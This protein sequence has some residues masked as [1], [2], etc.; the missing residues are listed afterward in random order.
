MGEVP[1]RVGVKT[2]LAGSRSKRIRDKRRSH[3]S[4]EQQPHGPLAAQ[5]SMPA[6]GLQLEKQLR[7][8]RSAE[9]QRRQIANKLEVQRN[10]SGATRR[11]VRGAALRAMPLH[12]LPVGDSWFDYPLDD[13][14]NPA[15]NQA[16]IGNGILGH[17]QLQSMGNP[18]P[19]I[20]SL[21]YHGLSATAMLTYE[22]QHEILDALKDPSQWNNGVTADGILVSAG[23]DDVVGDSFAIYLGYKR[24]GLDAIRFQ[25]ILD[26]VQASYLDLFALRDI[27][28]AEVNIDPKQMPIFGHCYD[29]AIPNGEPAGYGLWQ[30]GPW[31][32]PSLNFAGYDYNEGLNIVQTTIDTFKQKLLELAN[33]KIVPPGKTTNNFILIDTTTTLTRNDKLPNGWANELHPYTEGFT[34]LAA[35]FLAALQTHYPG[36]I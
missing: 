9:I 19:N 31:L 2:T 36:R 3:L 14:G 33:D 28:A 20:L 11:T 12:F 21:A 25:G 29:Y 34:L 15:N 8:A 5:P 7:D 1:G 10:R 18:P 4:A 13:Y 22:R 6:A 30:Q 27:A 26:S 23:G 24:G 17:T 35:K 32:Q 16:I